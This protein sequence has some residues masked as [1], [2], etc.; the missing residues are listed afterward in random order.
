MFDLASLGTI[1]SDP[2]LRAM[3]K[4]VAVRKINS[5]IK[6]IQA[7][8]ELS[9]Y[10]FKAGKDKSGDADPE[11]R[12]VIR[13]HLEYYGALI[14]LSTQFHNRLIENLRAAVT[15]VS[16]APTQRLTLHLRAGRGSIVKSPFKI[17]NSR[18][19]PV[20]ITCVA[21]P[22]VSEAGDEMIAS[23]VTFVPP[24]AEIPPGGEMVFEA[25]LPVIPDFQVGKTYFATLTA[26]GVDAM[27]I[28]A[29]LYVEADVPNHGTPAASDLGI[30]VPPS[31]KPSE[32]TVA[33]PRARKVRA[34]A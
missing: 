31:A 18:A 13:E 19:E 32:T 6:T 20:F 12:R 9:K 21:S 7:H 1:I 14:D 15:P 8:S 29:R 25:V 22:F 4:S 3:L 24:S 16:T 2:E 5:D 28:V 34:D 33:K 11:M 26:E 10:V 17:S 23:P 30:T 27:S